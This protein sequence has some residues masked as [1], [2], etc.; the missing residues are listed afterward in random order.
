MID[1]LGQIVVE[2]RDANI[3][4][5]R[6]RGGEPAPQTEDYEGDALGPGHYKRFVVV[7]RLGRVRSDAPVQMVR[8]GI[9][10]YGANQQDAGALSGE[11]SDALHLVGGRGTAPRWVYASVEDEG[12]DPSKDPDTGQPYESS[13]ITIVART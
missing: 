10:S 3:A 5:G 8:L 1:P 6:V 4:S 12:G 13:V 7:S 9:R 2:L 11:V